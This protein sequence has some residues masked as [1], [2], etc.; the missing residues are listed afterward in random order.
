MN[1]IEMN[2]ECCEYFTV[3]RTLESHGNDFNG[4]KICLERGGSDPRFSRNILLNNC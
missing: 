4:K 1:N 3:E 2:N